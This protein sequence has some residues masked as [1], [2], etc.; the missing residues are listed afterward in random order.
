ME[1]RNLITSN[2]EI[3]AG[4]PTLRGT[5]ISVEFVLELYAAGWTQDQILENY[6]HLNAEQ[7]HAACAF[8]AEVMREEEFVAVAKLDG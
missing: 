4:K 8:A 2:P 1:W 6:P 5:R 7:L 3:L